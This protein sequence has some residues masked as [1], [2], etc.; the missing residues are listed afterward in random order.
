M[1]AFQQE[2]T[3]LRPYMVPFYIP[4]LEDKVQNI[5]DEW[6]KKKNKT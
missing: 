6:A 3:V 2:D 4:A 1:Q 5:K